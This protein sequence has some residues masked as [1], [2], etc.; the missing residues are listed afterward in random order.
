MLARGGEA[1]GCLCQPRFTC[2]PTSEASE[3]PDP[4]DPPA[5]IVIAPMVQTAQAD[6]VPLANAYAPTAA[7]FSNLL[8]IG[9]PP[10]EKTGTCRAE[11][12]SQTG[13]GTTIYCH[14]GSRVKQP[15]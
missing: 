9:S 14:D 4:S 10:F 13:S 12:I 2:E 5:D 7:V 8:D 11:T 3:A 6:A 15:G 1:G